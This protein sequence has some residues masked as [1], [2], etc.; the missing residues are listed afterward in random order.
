MA[1]GV[2]VSMSFIL[3]RPDSRKP[4][5]TPDAAML[6][7]L[8]RD[9]NCRPVLR[10]IL[11]SLLHYLNQLLSKWTTN[12]TPTEKPEP[13]MPVQNM[14]IYPDQR[15]AASMKQTPLR[16]KPTGAQ[17]PQKLKT[18]QENNARTSSKTSEKC[19]P[20]P[21]KLPGMC[22][23]D[24]VPRR[25]TTFKLL[26]SKFIRSI[27]KPPITHQREVG[28]LS[29][30]RGADH[31]KHGQCSEPS[32]RKSQTRREQGLK[33][34]GAVKDIVAKFAMAEQ[35]ETGEKLVKKEPVKPRLITRGIVL[36]SLMEKFETVATVHKGSDFKSSHER[37]SGGVMVTNKVKQRV[38]GH[39]RQKQRTT[40]QTDGKQ[41]RHKRIKSESGEVRMKGNESTKG[42]QQRPE[43]GEDTSAKINTNQK[44]EL[45]KAKQIVWLTE[46]NFKQKAEERHSLQS[47]KPQF[48][49]KDNKGRTSEA[50][51]INMLN[52]GRQE[53]FGF[54]SVT[55]SLFPEPCR[56]LTQLEA[57]MYL[58]VGT[59][60]T[61]FHLWSTCFDS[62]PKMYSVEPSGSTGEDHDKSF[63]SRPQTE[64]H[65]T[66]AGR[67]TMKKTA[68]EDVKPTKN[69]TI[70]RQLP[71]FLIPRVQRF[72]S[73]RLD[74]NQT[75]SLQPSVPDL[76]NID[77][78]VTVQP[79]HP[80]TS[81][82]ALNTAVAAC[83]PI[84]TKEAVFG[85]ITNEK[86]V[87]IPK[88]K[89]EV[90]KEQSSIVINNTDVPQRFRLSEGTASK[91]T[92]E[93]TNTSEVTSLKISPERDQRWRPKYT[94]INYGDPSVK[95]TYKPKIIRFTDTFTF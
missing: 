79:P 84:N 47:M 38:D 78:L 70:Q 82:T 81:V 73:P 57:Q 11:E 14:T 50:R 75:D 43:Q 85:K 16:V 88:D 36:S 92:C 8:V 62:S 60:T 72:G 53:E 54:E 67:H 69:E 52:Y 74:I 6:R 87:A 19:W 1:V 61:C 25:L 31:L 22:A 86:T 64:G 41:K 39:E 26:Q 66:Y 58:H 17:L 4:S 55:E 89:E 49:E 10:G 2:K 95:Q 21:Q 33:K 93:D 35:K 65:S 3:H 37:P 27:P 32:V 24:H 56:T 77:P 71:K 23:A 59:I 5:N 20:N 28:M 29:S 44:E 63:S 94:T 90:A 13:D 12:N 68:V 91:A 46:M 18:T 76:G 48:C 15:T 80:D 7:K 9:R 42:Q 40:D 30:S 34:G 51:I 45:L 83:P